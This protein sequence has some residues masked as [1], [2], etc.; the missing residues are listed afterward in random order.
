MKQHKYIIILIVLVVALSGTGC[1]KFLETNSPNTVSVA[2]LF[3]DYE[4]ART[5]IAGCYDQLK[6]SNFHLPTHTTL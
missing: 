1:R 2:E 4:G 6:A 5:A 3:T